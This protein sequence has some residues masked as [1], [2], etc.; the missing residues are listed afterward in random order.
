MVVRE[1]LRLSDGLANQSFCR[2]DISRV[3]LKSNS[4]VSEGLLASDQSQFDDA[5]LLYLNE[6]EIFLNG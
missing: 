4:A 6:N 1:L 5:G 2:S 3:R